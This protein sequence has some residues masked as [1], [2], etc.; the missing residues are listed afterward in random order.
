MA[1]TLTTNY[2]WVKPEIAAS[3][4]TWGDKLNADL[5]Q[6][7]ATVFANQQAGVQVGFISMFAGATP[8]NNWMICN[9][10]SLATASY[11][12]LFSAI[13]YT[14][15]GSGANFNLPNLQAR[16]ALGAGG[17][18]G[19]ALAATGGAASTVLSAAQLAAH[20]H[21]I[22]DIPHTHG[23]TQTPHAHPDG[24]HSHNATGSQAPHNHTV[25][26][27]FGFGVG[28]SAPPNPLMNEG[29]VP[30]S[31]AQPPITVTVAPASSNIGPQN[32]NVSV[33]SAGTGLTT[34]GPTGSGQPVPTMPPFLGIN[35]IIRVS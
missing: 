12:T 2:Q 13:G 21:P 27:S 32:A 25:P 14:Y 7:D 31:N 20:S 11:A 33:N 24:L 23:V 9:G 15:G 34:T 16:F 29:S 26:G 6:I 22:V 4:A 8:P 35:F 18:G 5:D 30:T 28:G 17:S 1:D 19:V 3:A 10:A